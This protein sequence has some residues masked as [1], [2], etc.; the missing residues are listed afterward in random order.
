MTTMSAT[1][2]A[3]VLWLAASAVAFAQWDDSR[4]RPF[5]MDHRGGAASAVDLSFLLE[6]PAGKHG[7][8][9][10]QGGHLV[11]ADGRRM[12]LWGVHL[13]DWSKGSVMLPPKEDI[14]IWA[15]ALA[16]F[17]VN[18]VRLHF[19]DLA[20]PRGVI[21]ATRSD[22]REFDA[23][24]LDRLD[25]LVAELKRRGIYVD[26]NL[27]V[28]RSYKAGDG[29]Q[30]HDKIRWAKGLVLFHPRLI[31]LQKEY[32]QRILTHHNP[33]TKSEYRHEPAVAI[34]EILNENG[35]W[36]GFRAPTPYYDG[37]LT[38]QYNDWLRRKLSP[39][40]LK[41][42][43]ELAGAPADA[44]IPRLQGPE[45]ASAPRERLYPEVSF[46]MEKENEFYQDMT[47]YL[48]NTL[49]VKAPIIGTADHGHSSSSYPMLASLARL[50]IVDG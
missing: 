29:V 17:G 7:F 35:L 8:L 31:E 22:S 9:R 41:K 27:N 32:A 33:Y 23:R 20:A 16:R 24:Q 48:R 45:V 3:P 40:E 4:L 42:L 49:G 19:I 28:G 26:L 34:V 50:D 36:A 5:V 12:R 13:T 37:L 30:D 25:Y 15:G 14:P 1:V 18:C 21:D 6:P 39:E 43:R 11:K 2:C 10:V 46:F 44:P 38:R 47:A